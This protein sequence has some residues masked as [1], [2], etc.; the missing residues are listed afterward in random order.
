MNKL[1]RGL[2]GI[3]T[4]CLIWS[5]TVFADSSAAILETYTGDSQISVYVKGT[6]SDMNDVSIQIATTEADQFNVKPISEL[7]KPMKTLVMVDNSISISAGNRE[8]IAEFLQN[9]ISDRLNNEEVCIATFSEEINIVIDYSSDYATLKQAIGSISYQDQET[10]LT[11]VLYDLISAQYTHSVEDVYRRIII[12]SD[13]VDNKS[14]GYTKDEL[15]SLLK[16]IQVPIYTIGSVNKNNNDE[17]ENMFALSR[18]TSAEYFLLDDI[19]DV[20]AITETLNKDREIVR[21]TI[22]PSEEMMDGSKKVVKIIFDDASTLTTEITMPQKVQEKE[23]QVELVEEEVIEQEP[24]IEITH[25]KETDA[26]TGFPI[27]MVI[28]II[29]M[30]AIVCV[31]LIML[32]K[33]KS[34]RVKFET[35]DD[36]I[37]RELEQNTRDSGDNTEVIGSFHNNSDEGSTVMIW[38]QNTTYQVVLTDVNLPAKSFRVPISNSIIIGRPKKSCAVNLDIALS[39][40][41]SVSGPHCEITVK[42]E[43]FYIKDLQSSNGTYVNDRKILAETEIFSGN[44]LK[45]G[46][47]EMRFEV[48]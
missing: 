35:L 18:M 1:L 36:N 39:Y 22:T 43:K 27:I 30:A 47:L 24:V 37:L 25:E 46:R 12:V 40:D 32:K 19:A 5:V 6:E 31:V 26:S 28:A 42:D 11:D 20:L 17:L 16:D 29:V 23:P 2:I 3:L 41:G 48:R 45:F 44:I 15:Y 21:L 8:K 38:N 7:D 10:Y 4:G 33:K 14:L 9:L 34:N 13:G